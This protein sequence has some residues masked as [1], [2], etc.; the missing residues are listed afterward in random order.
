MIFQYYKKKDFYEKIKC[1][2][3]IIICVA[4][5]FHLLSPMQS[6]VL[7]HAMLRTRIL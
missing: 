7:A 4:C 5:T 6:Y 3:D 2:I 1:N